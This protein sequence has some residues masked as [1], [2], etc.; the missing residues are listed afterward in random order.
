LRSSL[1]QMSFRGLM[2]RRIHFRSA[3]DGV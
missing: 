3:G 2:S 1:D